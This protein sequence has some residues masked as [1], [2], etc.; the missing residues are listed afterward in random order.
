METQRIVNAAKGT[1]LYS[2]IIAKAK[3]PLSTIEG[4]IE[5]P[6]SNLKNSIKRASDC[7]SCYACGSWKSLLVKTVKNANE[8]MN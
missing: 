4:K 6:A 7:T 2:E 5:E 3:K 1:K 8:K